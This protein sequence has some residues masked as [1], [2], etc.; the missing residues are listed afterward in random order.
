VSVEVQAWGVFRDSR[1]IST[2][3]GMPEDKAKEQAASLSK[4]NPP[5]VYVAKAIPHKRVRVETP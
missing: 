3:A 2:L 1:M 4:F 5:A